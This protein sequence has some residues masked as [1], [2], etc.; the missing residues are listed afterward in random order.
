MRLG[1]DLR[2]RSGHLPAAG[3]ISG[4]AA[5]GVPRGGQSVGHV[6][7][8][9]GERDAHPDVVGAPAELG[10]DLRRDD[11]RISS[12]GEIAL[13]VRADRSPGTPPAAAR[14]GELHRVVRL[15]PAG[16]PPRHTFMIT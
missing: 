10:R 8:D 2:R 3:V 14:H 11:R 13:E 7:G 15:G 1:L 9:H 16:R 6:D 5:E 4:G 12:T